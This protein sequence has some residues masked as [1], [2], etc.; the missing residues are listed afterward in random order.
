MRHRRGGFAISQA[1]VRDRLQITWQRLSKHKKLLKMVEAM[2]TQGHIKFENVSFRYNT[3]E[4][5]VL[6]SIDIEIQPGQTVVLVGRTGSRKSTMAR[7]LMC[8]DLLAEAK[9]T[10]W[11]I[12]V[13]GHVIMSVSVA[14]L[15]RQIGAAL[16]SPRGGQRL[17]RS[18]S[19]AE[20]ASLPIDTLSGSAHWQIC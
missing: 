7:M 17:Y 14:S 3:E 9:S 6:P 19:A 10:G 13:D 11:K 2:I 4:K 16:D 1:T 12:L 5:N 18:M 8:L 20:T 15:R